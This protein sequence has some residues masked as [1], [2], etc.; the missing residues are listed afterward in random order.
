MEMR[1]KINIKI[2]GAISTHRELEIS[3]KTSAACFSSRITLKS[4]KTNQGRIASNLTRDCLT[5]WNRKRNI[6]QFCAKYIGN[7]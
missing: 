4:G 6:S 2:Q 5:F 7:N 1:D 3:T